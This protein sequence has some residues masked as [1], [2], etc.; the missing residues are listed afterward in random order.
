MFYS[1]SGKTWDGIQTPRKSFEIPDCLPKGLVD[2]IVEQRALVNAP[3]KWGGAVTQ[4]YPKVAAVIG[5]WLVHPGTAAHQDKSL[6]SPWNCK[7]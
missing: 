4:K 6:S 1:S 2:G 7:P 3:A 5:L